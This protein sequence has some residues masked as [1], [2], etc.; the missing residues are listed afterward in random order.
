M[1]ARAGKVVYVPGR[2]DVGKGAKKRRR[3]K[4][5]VVTTT[6]EGKITVS[7]PGAEQA[8]RQ[9]RSSQRR[10]KRIVREAA[11][12]KATQRVRVRAKARTRRAEHREERA[13]KRAL[14]LLRTRPSVKPA[15][16]RPTLSAAAPREKPSSDPLATAI[17]TQ[18]IEPARRAKVLPKGK[19]TGQ[20]VAEVV[21]EVGT[22]AA[23]LPG[24]GAGKLATRV[25]RATKTEA[26]AIE[27]APRVGRRKATSGGRLLG[28]ADLRAAKAA[29]TR[30]ARN[31]AAHRRNLA[32]ARAARRNRPRARARYKVKAKRKGRNLRTR[33]GREGR[34][35]ARRTRSVKLG[36]NAPYITTAGVPTVGALGAAV[37]GHLSADPKQAALRTLELLPGLVIST[38][39]LA[40]QAAKYV[41]TGDAEGLKKRIS[42]DV[43]FAIRLAKVM[44]SGDKERVRRFVEKHGYIAPLIVAPSLARLG[45]VAKRGTSAVPTRP[46]QVDVSGVGPV[47]RKLTRKGWRKRLSRDKAMAEA[48]AVA[49]TQRAGLPVVR[50]YTGHRG[51]RGV[52]KRRKLRNLEVDRGDVMA[53]V[54]EEG[55]TPTRIAE[56]FEAVARKWGDRPVFADKR[57]GGVTGHDLIDYVRHDPGVWKDKAFWRVVDA[58][59]AQ[60]PEVRRSERVVDIEQAK[61]HGVALAE[62]RATPKARELIPGARSRDQV[63]TFISKSGEGGKRVRRLRETIRAAEGKAREL[64]AE[65]RQ[66]EK[67]DRARQRRAARPTKSQLRELAAKRALERRGQGVPEPRRPLRVA[68]PPKVA[69]LAVTRR[70]QQ[71]LLTAEADIRG[72]RAELVGSRRRHKEIARSLRDPA[73]AAALKREFDAEL[74][75]VREDRGLV[76]GAYVPHTDVG[77]EGIPVAQPVTRAAKKIYK[78]EAGPASLAERGRVDYS[79]STIVQAGTEAPR[80]RAELHAFAD[81]AVHEGAIPIRDPKTG[82]LKRIAT[83]EQFE[84][85][86]TPEQKGQGTLFPLSQFKQAVREDDIDALDGIVARLD[87]EIDLAEGKRGHKYV[88]LDRDYA[89]E[90][91]AQLSAPGGV[92]RFVQKWSRGFSRAILT[93]PAWVEGQVLAEGFQAAHAINPLNPFNVGHFVQGYVRGQ[94]KMD[95]TRRLEFRAEAGA[96]PGMGLGPR[97]FATVAGRTHRGLADNFRR[98]ER[99]LPLKRLIQAVRFDW[100][101]A[102]DRA[103]G[104]EFRVMVAATKAHK[105]AMGLAVGLERLVKGQRELSEKLA[106]MSPAQRVEWMTRDTPGKRRVTDYLDDTMGNWRA[107]S[108]HERNFAPAMIFYNFLRMS[109]QWPF[110]T[111]PKR[112][113]ARAAVMYELASSHNEQLRALL[114]GPPSWFGEYATAIVYG[115]EWKGGALKIRATRIVPGASAIVEAL[116]AGGD[117]AAQRALNPI[118]SYFN[119]L[120]NGI[121]P[122]SGEKVDAEHL[123]R[124]EKAIARAGLT[125]SLLFNT[126]PPA[127]AADQ[128][129]GP[130]EKTSLPLI[131][132]RYQPSALGKLLEKLQGSPE[133]RAITSLFNPTP[134]ADIDKARDAAAMGRIFEIWRTS[135]SDAQDAVKSDDSLSEGQKRRRLEQMEARTTEADNEL[136]RLYRKYDI[137]YKAEERRALAEWGRLTYDEK[138]PRAKRGRVGGSAGGRIGGK[139]I[140]GGVGGPVGRAGGG[141]I[142]GKPLP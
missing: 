86:L 15:P 62:Q 114:G 35:V 98:L 106:A 37:G 96:L 115:E 17:E 1:P 45:T 24:L 6:A 26:K 51:K 93:S 41:A 44:A 139:P 137:A 126:Y 12:R 87:S 110:Y 38:A 22:L 73:E 76:R 92:L 75:A 120:I 47:K 36:V 32:A 16:R 64:R 39:D 136:A 65:L 133:Q 140:G 83:R 100:G 105:D 23:P 68:K 25:L 108:R 10:V 9:A 141:S 82:K 95:P 18:V 20:K 132:P 52:G 56:N 48:R 70:R 135:G 72:M 81:R 123:S 29:S 19:T 94:R 124:E 67:Q 111:F 89:A 4:P 107:F 53:L 85:G 13:V 50:A 3:R 90:L 79:L 119:A 122:L 34:K 116:G 55:L 61:T 46:K 42:E 57:K 7:G 131:G 49:K 117:V 88:L 128:L 101:K 69:P 91:K 134:W 58:Y 118:A 31:L 125:L 2:G 138:P 59:R 33:Y 60:E 130:K 80:I 102:I 43:K 28:E 104:G 84:R 30:R 54:A 8:R 142:G 99:V 77:R 78:R 71:Q 103:K 113:P 112:H 40:A 63:I 109:M 14:G 74:A 66:L 11:Q 127:R 97:E 5:T 21:A 121:D 27:A 129:R